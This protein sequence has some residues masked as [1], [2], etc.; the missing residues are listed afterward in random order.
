MVEE[1]RNQRVSGVVKRSVVEL[2]FGLESIA[3]DN[4]ADNVMEKWICTL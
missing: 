1:P 4:L 3:Y 2:G